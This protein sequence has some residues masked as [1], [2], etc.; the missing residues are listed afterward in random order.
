MKSIGL[1][2]KSGLVSGFN[3]VKVVVK[4]VGVGMCEVLKNLVEKF[5]E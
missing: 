3:V 4:G 5:V 1:L 2:I